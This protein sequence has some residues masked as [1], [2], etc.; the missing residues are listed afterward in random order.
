MLMHQLLMLMQ[1]AVPVVVQNVFSAFAYTGNGGTKTITNGIDLAGQGGLVLI[2]GRDA[3][4]NNRAFD[5]ARGK[6]YFLTP[7]DGSASS[8]IAG[9]VTAFNS[10]GFSLGTVGGSNSTNGNLATYSSWTFRKAPRFFDVV[11]WAGDGVNGRQ[12]PHNLGIKPGMVI[13][14]RTDTTGAWV[15]GVSYNN[16]GNAAYLQLN[17]TAATPQQTPGYVSSFATTSTDFVVNS[18]VD[19]SAVNAS[20]GTYVAYLFAH[21]SAADGVIQCASFTTDGSGNGSFNFG[22]TQ[23]VQFIALKCS[24]TTGD[25]ELFDTARTPGFSGNDAR[26]MANLTSVEDSVARLSFSGTT[27]SFAGLSASQTYV[28][29]AIRAPA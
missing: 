6:D 3:A 25:W 19:L 12:I 5:T 13:I 22:W 10:N 4:T 23:G 17:S 29:A 24:S 1:K 2:K 16:H 14:K 15:V 26:L 8:L 20:G 18:G 9:L 28:F 7:N 11:T 27:L 21:D